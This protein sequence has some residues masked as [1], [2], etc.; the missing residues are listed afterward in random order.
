MAG[1]DQQLF[2]TELH[3]AAAQ[4]LADRLNLP[5][6]GLTP[7]SAASALTSEGVGED[8]VTRAQAL[9]TTC[10]FARFAPTGQSEDDRTNLYDEAE[11]LVD[12]LGRVI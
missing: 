6:A 9:M 3:R 10:D 12:E 4:F 7:A 11:S 2:Y 8:L 5:A 1:D